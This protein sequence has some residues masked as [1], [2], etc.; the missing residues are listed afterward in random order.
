MITISDFGSPIKV[1]SDGVKARGE[2]PSKKDISVLVT[3]ECIRQRT[4]AL[5]RQ[6]CKDYQGDIHGV[7]ILRG[8][9]F[10]ASDL[11]REIYKIGG[12][13]VIYETCEVKSYNGEKSTGNIQLVK[14]VGKIEGKDVLIIE[15]I[16]DTGTT[17]D[18][19]HTYFAVNK[20]ARSVKTCCLLDKPERRVA[21]INV[22]YVGFVIPN[23]FIVGYGMDL[24]ERYRNVPYIGVL[25]R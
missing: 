9:V 7:V 6:I 3:E 22:E 24:D 1:T 18:F 17:L 8:S 23:L 5:A 21:K 16:V 10:F 11:M 14:D 2:R 20:G 4:K 19:L 13:N 25:K 12:N 15:D